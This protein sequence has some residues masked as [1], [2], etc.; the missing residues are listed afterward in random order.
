MHCS[1]CKWQD[2]HRYKFFILE[3][4]Q[5][6]W[7]VSNRAHLRKFRKQKKLHPLVL[8]CG[9]LGDRCLLICFI[10]FLFEVF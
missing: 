10:M 3:K 9:V 6:A 5:V 1:N 2:F 4:S 8:H 7:V